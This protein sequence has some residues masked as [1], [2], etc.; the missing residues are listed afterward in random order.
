M[1]RGVLWQIDTMPATSA[2]EDAFAQLW[3]SLE[4]VSTPFGTLALFLAR[5]VPILLIHADGEKSICMYPNLLP[6][7][8]Y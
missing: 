5:P 7:F 4:G 2:V 8:G 3:P 6:S 1:P